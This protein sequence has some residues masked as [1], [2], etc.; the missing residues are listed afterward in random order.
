MS[1][2]ALEEKVVLVTGA[3]SGIGKTVVEGLLGANAKVAATDINDNKP[4]YANE[5]D[6]SLLYTHLDVTNKE[7]VRNVIDKTIE[8]F[9]HL[10]AIVNNAGINIPRL[11]V[12]PK[13]P[14]AAS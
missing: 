9:G 12:D 1:W 3:A 13:D 14:L 5:S 10:D 11:L 8:K 6:E 4:D 2:L 7:D